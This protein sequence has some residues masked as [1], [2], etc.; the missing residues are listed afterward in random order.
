MWKGI[1]QSLIKTGYSWILGPLLQLPQVLKLQAC[2]TLPNVFIEAVFISKTILSVCACGEQTI[3][4]K[5]FFPSTMR[6]SYPQAWLQALTH[7]TIFFL[8]FLRL[9]VCVCV[10]E[11]E[12]ERDSLEPL[13][14]TGITWHRLISWGKVLLCSPSRLPAHGPSVSPLSTGTKVLCLYARLWWPYPLARLCRWESW[15]SPRWPVGKVL[16]G[17]SSCPAVQ[18]ALFLVWGCDF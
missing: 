4:C 14:S 3:T 2:T 16:V 7:W 17:F 18:A 11:R 8:S 6:N 5:S 15:G 10:C 13:V 12:R 9:C 1:R